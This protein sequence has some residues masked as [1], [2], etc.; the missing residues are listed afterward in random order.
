MNTDLKQIKQRIDEFKI[1]QTEHDKQAIDLLESLYLMAQNQE[2]I[3]ELVS[4]A[5]QAEELF[6]LDELENFAEQRLKAFESISHEI[7]RKYSPIT[8]STKSTI[9]LIK[10]YIHCKDSQH[11]VKI[12]DLVDFLEKEIDLFIYY[13]VKK[14]QNSY[15]K[16]KT[17]AKPK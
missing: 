6:T 1:K 3:H 10:H 7:R 8:L 2:R 14:A 11:G 5:A 15:D 13:E 4:S 16:E 9:Q 17:S 12:L